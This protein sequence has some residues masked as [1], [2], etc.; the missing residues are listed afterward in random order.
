MKSN[1][2]RRACSL[3]LAVITALSLA[4]IG[5]FARTGASANGGVYIVENDDELDNP[6]NN[7]VRTTAAPVTAAPTTAAPAVTTA[8]SETGDAIGRAFSAMEDGL[9]KLINGLSGESTTLASPTATAAPTAAYTVPTTALTPA[10]AAP[11][12]NAGNLTANFTMPPATTAAPAVTAPNTEFTVPAAEPTA[13]T[14]P[15]GDGIVRYTV[16]GVTQKNEDAALSGSTLTI[17][18]FVAAVLILILVIIL[19]LVIMTRRNEFNSKVMNRSTLPNVE[20]PDNQIFPEDGQN[21]DFSDIRGW[22]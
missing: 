13:G 14:A 19:A 15:Q 7:I 22:E 11:A 17:V 8:G 4:A 21:G 20:K 12:M 6:N 10:T 3:L 16:E 18:V 1:N 5:V 9:N 2:G